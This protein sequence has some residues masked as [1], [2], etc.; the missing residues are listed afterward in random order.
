MRVRRELIAIQLDQSVRERVG[1]AGRAVRLAVPARVH[2]G[3]QPEVG[4][5]VDRVPDVVEQPRQQPLAHAVRQRAE[6][7]VEAGEVGGVERRVA[8]PLVGREQAG[9]DLADRRPA[10]ECAVVHHLDVGVAS[11]AAAAAPAPM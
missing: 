8:Q 4:T 5:E 2:V 10:N 1:S 11:P 7:E 3:R 6:H 9:I